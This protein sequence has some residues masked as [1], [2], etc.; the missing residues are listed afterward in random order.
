MVHRH[1][2]NNSRLFRFVKF[3]L[4]VALVSWY[5]TKDARRGVYKRVFPCVGQGNL[6][7]SSQRYNLDFI[8]TLFSLH[9]TNPIP[10]TLNMNGN[11][12]C[13]GSASACNCGS[14]CT[15]WSFDFYNL[16][17][18]TNKQTIYIYILTIPRRHLHGLQINVCRYNSA[19][20]RD[21]VQHIQRERDKVDD[22]MTLTTSC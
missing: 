17:K 9:F 15:F 2:E 8:Y 10:I 1:R 14:S 19:W 20:G 22:V 6:G 16:K 21:D 11:C 5:S 7:R 18:Q 4:L 12:G 13:N 3:N